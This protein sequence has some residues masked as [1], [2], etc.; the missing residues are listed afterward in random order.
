M[1]N[2]GFSENINSHLGPQKGPSVSIQNFIIEYKSD[3]KTKNTEEEVLTMLRKRLFAQ[4][5]SKGLNPVIE[6][7]AVYNLNGKMLVTENESINALIV[8]VLAVDVLFCL[9]IFTCGLGPLI[10]G[11]IPAEDITDKAVADISL[12]HTA[13]NKNVLMKKVEKNVTFV[14][15]AYMGNITKPDTKINS[16]LVET[17]DNALMEIA[18][19]VAQVATDDEDAQKLQE[20]KKLKDEGLLTDEEYEKKSKSITDGM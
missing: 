5:K 2:F 10:S 4:L 15:N 11:S 1:R 17:I 6:G 3:F 18:E 9:P 20:L 8:P 16:Y 19:N 14:I 7:E 13:S 12:I